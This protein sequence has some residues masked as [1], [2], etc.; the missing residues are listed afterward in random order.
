[1]EFDAYGRQLGW[2][3]LSR[4]GIAMAREAAFLLISPV[5]ITR[6]FEYPFV[7]QYLP[8]RPGVCLDVSSPGLLGL[9]VAD[10]RLVKSLEIINP[11]KRDISQTSSIVKL[12]QLD[13]V[14]C[15]NAAIDA[16]AN[17]GPSFDCI[18]SISVI[19]HISG[20]YDD[21]GAMKMMY[22]LLKPGGRLIVT[23]PV[24]RKFYE[25]YREEDTYR[26]DSAKSG[27]SYFFQRVYD[28][29]ALRARLFAPIGVQPAVTRWFGEKAQGQYRKYEKRWVSEGLSCTADDSREICDNYRE[30]RSWDEMPGHGVCG[31]VVQKPSV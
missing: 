23:T 2:R 10:K 26:L 11:D 20:A 5:S 21:S 7:F 27:G 17:R 6:Y 18:W 9:Y 16:F 15:T 4:G 25:E 12:L 24:D 1:M 30:F 8:D 22:D 29:A 14:S 19:E 28:E 31:F 3:V 13:N